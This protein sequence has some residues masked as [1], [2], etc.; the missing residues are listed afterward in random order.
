MKKPKS[1]NAKKT[2]RKSHRALS[3]YKHISFRRVPAKKQKNEKALELPVS[4]VKRG[5][6]ERKYNDYIQGE[7]LG[8]G[9][10]G[11]VFE[12][13]RENKE[14]KRECPYVMKVQKIRDLP[15]F[16][17]EVDMQQLVYD[18]LKLAPRIFD[19]W[20]CAGNIN[21][22]DEKSPL[23]F[24]VMERFDGTLEDFLRENDTEPEYRAKLYGNIWS[25]IEALHEIGIN[26]GD[27]SER[28]VL[29]KKHGKHIQFVLSDFG[30]AK[31]RTEETTDDKALVDLYTYLHD[32][33]N[34]KSSMS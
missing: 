16:E 23:G 6:C 4:S 3:T 20:I 11:E 27:L 21:G 18:K 25:K 29:Y 26:H 19:A 5:T 34:R 22:V 8:A 10:Y 30:F 7:R 33:G 12:L 13:C 2:S 14:A 28:N 9:A 1:K 17:R 15:R 24:I 31:F 32:S